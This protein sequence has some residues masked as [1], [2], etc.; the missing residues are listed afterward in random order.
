[1]NQLINQQ[2][3]TMDFSKNIALNDPNNKL[4]NQS[5]NKNKLNL[6]KNKYDEKKENLKNLISENDKNSNV[7]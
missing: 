2:Q 5:M 6:N 1:M 4:K 3:N 7:M